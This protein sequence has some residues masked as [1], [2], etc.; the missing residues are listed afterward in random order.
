M[1][2][3]GLPKAIAKK[4]GISKKA[5]AVYRGKKKK[6][7]SNPRPIKA[8]KVKRKLARRKRKRRSRKMTIP[9]ALVGGVS[10]MFLA[11]NPSGRSIAEDALNGDINA[12]LYDF[13]ERF[14]CVNNMGNFEVGWIL[15]HYGP[16]IMGALISKF[17]GGSPINLN[18]R[19]AAANIPFIRI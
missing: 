4:Y 17:I 5:W 11:P 13:R 3:K 9:L 19:L 7:S 2:R 12:L 14:A 18:R 1:A 16:V 6:K 15:P 10:S 8:R